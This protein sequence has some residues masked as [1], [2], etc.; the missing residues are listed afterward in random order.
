MS[1]KWKMFDILFVMISIINIVISLAFGISSI[2]Y[3]LLAFLIIALISGKIDKDT[4]LLYSLFVPNKYLQLIAIPIYLIKSGAIKKR[5]LR[6]SEVAFLCYIAIIGIIN[7]VIYNGF[8]MGT[9]FQIGV[10]YCIIKMITT[11]GRSSGFAFSVSVLDKMFVLQVI[12]CVIDYLYYRKVDDY[13]MGT[14]IS[15]HY[16]GAFLLVYM[17]LLIKIRPP[18]IKTFGYITRFVIILILLWISDAKHV[19]AIFIGA[20]IISFLLRF[21]KI[22]N[23]ITVFVI[24]MTAFVVIGTLWVTSS[25][26]ASSLQKISLASTYIFNESFN[27]KIT[28]FARTFNEM[29]SLNGLFGFG[30]GQFGSQISLTLSK[31]IIYSWN[32]ALSAYKY[33]IEPYASAI[34]GIMT[35]WY[36]TYG[37]GISSMV[38]GYPLVSFIGL[39]AELGVVGYIWLLRIFDK[40]F[41]KND[42]VFILAFFLLTIFDTYFE[43]PCVFVLILIATFA[44]N[45]ETRIQLRIRRRTKTGAR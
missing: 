29:I 39:F 28:F 38:L 1:F 44:N 2:A 41:R 14:L 13:I 10:Y 17:Y 25:R 19:W 15:A 26:G 37:I 20:W 24:A 35:E 16:L 34:N 3:I 27:K 31:G 12:T 11:Y 22:K 42:I 5:N 8:F 7:C 43:I 30:V 9:L 40:R 18:Q 6:N 23:K 33:A 21:L 45:E 32:H 36:T 4:F